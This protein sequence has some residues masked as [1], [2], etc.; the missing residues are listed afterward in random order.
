MSSTLLIGLDGATFTILNPLMENGTMPFLKRFMTEGVSAELLSTPHP[1]TP[2]AFTSLATGRN[3]GNHGIYDFI[4]REERD[5]EIF[6]TLYD[7]RDIRCETIWSIASRQGCQIM[8][9]NFV[10]TAPVQDNIQG[11]IV[12]GMVSWRHLRRHI[13]PPNLYE[14][15]KTLPGFD[16]KKVAWEF[17]QMEKALHVLPGEEQQKWIIHQIEREQ[18]WFNIMKDL[19][20]KHP[21][22]LKV[23]VFDGMDKIQHICWQFLD[24]GFLSSKP[25]EWEKQI[26][27]LCLRYFRQ[28][29]EFIAELVEMVG[30]QTRT[31]I[32]S[33]HGFGPA[34]TRFR[35]NQF[36]ANAGYL[37][38]RDATI[39]EGNK[40][41]TDLA[42]LDWK[43]TTAYCPTPSS[44]GIYIQVASST[45]G[46]N[47]VL[48]EDYL[49]F[50]QT[51]V[52][53][54][55]EITDPVSGKRIVQDVLL[56]EKAFPGLAMNEAPDI[57]LVL[58]DHT[59]VSVSKGESIIEQ[60]ESIGGTHYPEGIFSAA[61][62]GIRQGVKLDQLSI[63][64]I[65]PML[66]YSLNLPIPENFEGR[67]PLE[68]F[69]NEHL[70]T[71]PVVVGAPAGIE[72]SSIVSTEP[73]QEVYTEEEKKNIYAQLQNLGYID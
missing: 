14:E 2:P 3:P 66:L 47:G 26:R 69:E 43:Q 5:G 60:K 65:A 11:Y 35:L 33:D 57:T 45:H 29:D 32:I 17:K 18:Q 40:D 59:F 50:R 44:N 68:M 22:D 64:D 10:L 13:Y 62:P 27:E 67:V 37:K 56:R 52:N 42:E 70:N 7:S 19:L 46:E 15:I 30:A 34:Y 54:L 9:L 21:T 73:Q 72:N 49:K 39:D 6:F 23:I 8:L 48:A 31:F 36:L 38:W 71:Y 24:P 28:L 4:R 51:L 12:P 53:K 16:A 25:S 20:H 1:L 61:G 41:D 58:H 55:F 63:L